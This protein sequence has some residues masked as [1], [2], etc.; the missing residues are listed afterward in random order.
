[1]KGVAIPFAIER[2]ILNHVRICSYCLVSGTGSLF[3]VSTYCPNPPISQ[4]AGDMLVQH[5]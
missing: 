4:I 1:M 5:I 2:E 3:T